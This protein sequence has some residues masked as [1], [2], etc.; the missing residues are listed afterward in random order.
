MLKS[1]TNMQAQQHFQEVLSI[2]NGRNTATR[3]K[4]IT[5]SFR[6]DE[7]TL[8]KLNEQAKN[9]NISLNAEIN[10]ILGKYVDWDMLASKVGMVPIARPI[11][12]EIFQNIMTKEQVIDLA[13]R[14]SKDVILETAHFMKG[15]LTLESFLSWL[16][17]RMEYCSKVNCVIEDNYNPQIKII[18]K[19]DLGENWS[20]YHKIV[21][22]YIFY[23]ILRK[24][25]VQIEASDSTLILCLK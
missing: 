9:N 24:T 2:L 21:L 19:H 18:F 5:K 14:V 12:S 22:D 17:T 23:H 7:D 1:S 3:T 11:L 6:L 13:D 20:I 8:E 15:S 16:K 4:G 25:N 10:N